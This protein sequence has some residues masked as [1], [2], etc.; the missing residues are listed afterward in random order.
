MENTHAHK[1]RTTTYIYD[2][3]TIKVPYRTSYGARRM[4]VKLSGSN[5][6]YST[7]MRPNTLPL[8]LHKQRFHASTLVAR[9]CLY[10]MRLV[11]WAHLCP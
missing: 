9:V 6:R 8:R 5:T 4:R 7:S 1:Y 3:T 10:V 2:T 11:P